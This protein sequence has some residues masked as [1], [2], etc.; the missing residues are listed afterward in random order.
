[1]RVW[2]LR[3]VPGSLIGED[4]QEYQVISARTAI[5]TNSCF[6]LFQLPSS[7]TN[8][9]SSQNLYSK[10]CVHVYYCF[11][12]LFTRSLYLV[13]TGY[14]WHGVQHIV[15]MDCEQIQFQR[16]LATSCCYIYVHSTIYIYIC[17]GLF[18]CIDSGLLM[19]SW[20]YTVTEEITIWGVKPHNTNLIQS[21]NQSCKWWKSI[22]K[23]SG[24]GDVIPCLT[25]NR[26]K[27]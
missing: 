7:S 4:K 8:N 1:M 24:R 18:L 27:N 15:C 25:W 21:K 17:M 9:T 10:L 19:E 11:P 2:P 3:L 26:N 12:L 20:L 5:C 14:I 13:K 22:M 16:R 6:L 23:Y